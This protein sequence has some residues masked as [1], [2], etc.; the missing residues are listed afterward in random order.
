MPFR[1]IQRRRWRY[2]WRCGLV[3]SGAQLPRGFRHRVAQHAIFTVLIR[4]ANRGFQSHGA[5]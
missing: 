3:A 4:L 2:N 1:P 5:A